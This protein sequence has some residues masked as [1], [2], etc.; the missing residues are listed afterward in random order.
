MPYRCVVV[1]DN[2]RF[3]QVAQRLLEVDGVLAV[4]TAADIRSALAL[5]DAELPE[6]V[7]IDVSLG[8]ESGFDLVR[9]L[10][11]RIDGFSRRIVII[12][13][14]AEEDYED[15]IRET[16]VAGFVSKSELSVD[17]IQR[18]LPQLA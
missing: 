11:E 14:R 3:V 6:V 4:Q 5:I 7:L 15:L 9:I 10:S 8:A 16:A 12:S 1:D 18:L 17:A 13:T 2:D